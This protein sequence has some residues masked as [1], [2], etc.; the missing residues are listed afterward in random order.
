M[1]V[2]LGTVGLN[3][4]ICFQPGTARGCLGCSVPTAWGVW[5]WG[6]LSSVASSTWS[7]PSCNSIL[8]RPS[9]QHV[10]HFLL[11][12]AWYH[13]KKYCWYLGW[14]D[15]NLLLWITFDS[16]FFLFSLSKIILFWVHE[17][18]KIKSQEKIKVSQVIFYHLKKILH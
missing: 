14:S 8:A 9:S 11:V 12:S 1:T 7:F 6:W 3:T 15:D 16:P 10:P 5:P 2:C 18:S 13:I 17:K 4:S